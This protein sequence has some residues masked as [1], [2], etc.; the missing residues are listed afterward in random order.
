MTDHAWGI[1][2]DGR[3]VVFREPRQSDVTIT[4]RDTGRDGVL[5][6][7]ASH[8]EYA[9]TGETWPQALYA[10]AGWLIDAEADGRVLR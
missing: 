5:R 10:L 9:D 7:Q 3:P 2:L 8:G 1:T 6:W 4:I